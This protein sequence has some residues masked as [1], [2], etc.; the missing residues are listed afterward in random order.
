MLQ[1]VWDFCKYEARLGPERCVFASL[2]LSL[3]GLSQVHQYVW[4]HDSVKEEKK[5]FTSVLDSIL[6]IYRIVKLINTIK[7]VH[8]M[9]MVC[10][11]IAFHKRKFDTL[12]RRKS[13]KCYEI[14]GLFKTLKPIN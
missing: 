11:I 5:L 9:L 2:S 10:I 3:M 1:E 6:Y 14:Q 12:S 13:V 4:Q 8:E 7:V